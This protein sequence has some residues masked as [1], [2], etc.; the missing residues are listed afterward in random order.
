MARISLHWPL[1]MFDKMRAIE[2][3]LLSRGWIVTPNCSSG[4]GLTITACKESFCI[5]VYSS[6]YLNAWLALARNYEDHTGEKLFTSELVTFENI[7]QI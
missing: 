7:S 3:A 4:H 2:Q 5:A 1:A 6:N